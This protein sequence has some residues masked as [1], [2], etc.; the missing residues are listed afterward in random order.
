MGGSRF[1]SSELEILVCKQMAREA[2]MT[3]RGLAS[4][5]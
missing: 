2:N 1:E 4:V 5:R 3:F